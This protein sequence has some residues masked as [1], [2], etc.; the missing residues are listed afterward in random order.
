MKLLFL[1]MMHLSAYNK[2]EPQLSELRKLYH[3]AGTQKEAA[4]R[5]V[6]LLSAVD[7]T[8]S[9]VLLSYRGACEMI[10]AKYVFNPLSK[11]KKFND[12]KM[13]LEKAISR[14]S[15][16]L[17]IRFLRY[18]IQKNL[19]SFLDYKGNIIADERFLLEKTSESNDNEL[20]EII[21]NYL[22]ATNAFT[23]AELKKLKN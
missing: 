20:K 15:S 8:A 12:G 14:D 21:V 3:L 9:P 17:E 11:L 1:L 10:Q 23:A 13:M 22:A 4:Q 6:S 7:S 16:N 5:M 18:S 2:P 19:P